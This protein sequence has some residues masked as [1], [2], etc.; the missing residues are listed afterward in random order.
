[1]NRTQREITRLE[2]ELDRYRREMEGTNCD[3]KKGDESR[4]CRDARNDKLQDTRFKLRESRFK[5]TE[6]Q[7]NY[8][9]TVAEVN[10]QAAATI[11]GF[12][13]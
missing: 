12:G 8:D 10:A 13:Q 4:D 7:R 5:L 11:P 2:G 9:M 3:G 6:D 1:M